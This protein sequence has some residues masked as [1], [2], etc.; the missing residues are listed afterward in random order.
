MRHQHQV[1]GV[2]RHAEMVDGAAAASIAGRDHVAP[3]GD[4][5]GARH[6]HHVAALIPP[7][8]DR[9]GDLAGRVS[10]AASPAS[11]PATASTRWRSTATVLFSTFSRVP[12]SRVWISPT[13]PAANRGDAE[14][15][16]I[17]SMQASSVSR[18][19]RTG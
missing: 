14:R 9:V 6:K 15:A 4:G 1:A 13:L 11:V 7:V 5:R 3:V 18:E 16:S 17:K 8:A 19:P 12:G 2:D 10:A